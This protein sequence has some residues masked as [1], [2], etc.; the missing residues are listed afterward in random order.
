MCQCRKAILKLW[1]QSLQLPREIHPKTLLERPITAKDEYPNRCNAH[2]R[3]NSLQRKIIQ[4]G[5]NESHQHHPTSHTERRMPYKPEVL[6]PKKTL[7]NILADDSN[8]FHRTLLR[9]A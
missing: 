3:S 4:L 8:N 5:L 6:C 7:L 2:T 1:V 9:N